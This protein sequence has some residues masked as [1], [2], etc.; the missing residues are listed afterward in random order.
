MLT[1]PLA[2]R[3]IFSILRAIPGLGVIVSLVETALP[4]SLSY[5][6]GRWHRCAEITCDRAGLICGGDLQAALGAEGKLR[7]GGAAL[8]KGFNPEEYAKQMEQMKG[9]PV[10]LLEAFRT[11]PMGPARVESMRLFSECEVLFRWRP[12][13]R[14]DIEPRSKEDV[15]RAC[16]SLLV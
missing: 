6:F 10:R 11:H 8:L 3:M 2:Q 4:A 7:T 12:E 13:M 1:N 5:V 16:E 9:S 15:D 14:G